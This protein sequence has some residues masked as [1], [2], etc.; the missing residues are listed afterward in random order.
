M[1]ARRGNLD[2]SPIAE[3]VGLV[4]G[5]RLLEEQISDCVRTCCEEGYGATEVAQALGITGRRC[6]GCQRG[7]NRTPKLSGLMTGSV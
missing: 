2:H 4:V 1:S 3:L 6:T 5:V 7:G